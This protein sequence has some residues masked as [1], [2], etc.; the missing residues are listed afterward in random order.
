MGSS[1]ERSSAPN[2][3]RAHPDRHSPTDDSSRGLIR[4][5][6]PSEVQEVPISGT[7]VPA[8]PATNDSIAATDCGKCRKKANDASSCFR[9]FQGAQYAPHEHCLTGPSPQSTL[10]PRSRENAV[11]TPRPFP[12]LAPESCRNRKR[13]T[14]WID[15]QCIRDKP[16]V[17]RR[18]LAKCGCPVL[19]TARDADWPQ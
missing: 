7:P 17:G 9:D 2:A 12:A 1:A 5:I 15:R 10:R 11:R 14:P 4:T 3:G 16:C 19:F 8:C 6:L 13:K 18:S